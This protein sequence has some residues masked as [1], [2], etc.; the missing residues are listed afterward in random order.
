[1]PLETTEYALGVQ[2]PQFPAFQVNREQPR[3]AM[4]NP[5]GTY[6]LLQNGSDLR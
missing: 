2:I 5:S 4:L 1:M 6:P 3:S